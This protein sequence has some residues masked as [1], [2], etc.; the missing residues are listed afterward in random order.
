MLFVHVRSL[1]NT[2]AWKVKTLG[3]C[4][5]FVVASTMGRLE[6]YVD[7]FLHARCRTYVFDLI[8]RVLTHSMA[9]K[10]VGRSGRALIRLELL[11]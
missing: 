3:S 5:N 9:S 11:A 2:R 8:C 1:C 4:M 10:C 6:L 7:V